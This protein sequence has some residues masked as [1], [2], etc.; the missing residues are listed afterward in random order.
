[1]P[2]R[3]LQI[4]YHSGLKNLQRKLGWTQVKITD[5]ASAVSALAKYR[6]PRLAKKLRNLFVIKDINF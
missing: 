3:I 5:R 1:M 2:A 4:S 6:C